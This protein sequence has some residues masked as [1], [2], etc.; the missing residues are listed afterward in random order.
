MSF[1]HTLR[2]AVVAGTALAGATA[3]AQN[4]NP[5]PT[6]GTDV[7]GVE[8]L[9]PSVPGGESWTLAEDPRLDPRFEP[10]DEITP[11]PDGSWK[12]L[13]DQVRMGVMTSSGYD[14]AAIEFN[15]DALA[16]KGFMQA[17]N[18]WKNVEITGYVKLN[19]TD[20]PDDNF[21][22][23]ARGGHHS[24]DIGCEGSAYKGGIYFDGRA[25]VEKE[26]WHVSYENAP[27]ADVTTPLGGRWVGFKY[28]MRN[29]DLG[30]KQGV[31]LE[32]WLDD[33]ADGRNFQK[34]Y[35]FVDDGTWGGDSGAC[36]GIDPAMPI[37]WGGPIATFR[38]DGATD[39]DFKWLSVREI[40]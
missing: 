27:Y 35:A 38:W 39:V 12:I 19:A 40:Q 5:L 37:T 26:S 34:V 2:T 9:Y 21:T 36:G 20:A 15:H 16:A 3:F 7:F 28:M 11:N 30:G 23:Y 1:R 33:D 18:D 29:V 25:R 22:W 10:Q 14:A 6:S 17:P 4:Q 13:S 31:E 8:M 32:L 24:D